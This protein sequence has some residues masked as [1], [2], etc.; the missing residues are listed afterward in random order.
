MT[1]YLMIARSVTYAQRMQRILAREGIRT[2]IYRAPRELTD[3]GCAYAIRIAVSDFEQA[4]LILRRE[5]FYPV[6]VFWHQ[7]GISREVTI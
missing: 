2:T 1:H 3:L 6:R 7:N 4:L 5:A